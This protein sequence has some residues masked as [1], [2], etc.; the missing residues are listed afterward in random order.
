[1]S[2][3]SPSGCRLD[4]ARNRLV[5]SSDISAHLAF[6]NHLALITAIPVA[7]ATPHKLMLPAI[8]VDLDSDHGGIPSGVTRTCG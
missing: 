8:L 6:N 1:M 3:G 2:F 5:R 7:A 4:A